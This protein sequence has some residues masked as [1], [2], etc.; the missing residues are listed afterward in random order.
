MPPIV[1]TGP[2][3]TGQ[4]IGKGKQMAKTKE[5]TM[6]WHNWGEPSEIS[7]NEF[8]RRVLPP[9]IQAMETT[10]MLEGDMYLSDYNTIMNAQYRLQ[11]YLKAIQDIE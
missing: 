8:M 1:F 10:R 3:A 4:A 6:T 9:L 2:A 11:H 5:P 7:L